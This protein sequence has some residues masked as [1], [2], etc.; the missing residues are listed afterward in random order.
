[1]IIRKMEKEDV[2]EIARIERE[3]F[4]SHAWS[5]DMILSE[6]YDPMKHYLVAT[7]NGALLGYGGFAHIENE[8]HIMNIA[9]EKN[10]RGRGYGQTI[11]SAML[12]EMRSLGILSATLEVSEQN[13][14][15]IKLYQK[16]GFL[17]NGR[18]PDYYKK[19]EAAL[20][21]WLYMK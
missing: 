20:I 19:G 16:S 1:M 11:L 21:F 8:G 9:V 17:Q 5:Y 4:S 14:P 12:K 10:C 6:L 3:T 15:A 7:E 2:E 13:A 18:R